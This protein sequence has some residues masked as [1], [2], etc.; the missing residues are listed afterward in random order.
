MVVGAQLVVQPAGGGGEQIAEL[1]DGTAQDLRLG[2][3]LLDGG[4]QPPLLKRRG[5]EFGSNGA[6]EGVRIQMRIRL[7]SPKNEEACN[8]STLA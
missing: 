7:H 5:S 3:G 2:P 6:A 4:A 1:G 8:A